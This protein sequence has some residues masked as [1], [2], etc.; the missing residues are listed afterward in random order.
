LTVEYG[1][2][3][4]GKTGPTSNKN[5]LSVHVRLTNRHRQ[6]KFSL[7]FYL[8]GESGEVL[9]QAEQVELL[10]T[11]HRSAPISGL[12]DLY[13][14]IG[15]GTQE[16]RSGFIWFLAEKPMPLKAIVMHD[17]ISDQRWSYQLNP[18]T[19]AGPKQAGY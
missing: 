12:S 18:K 9:P 16:E 6:R 5:C 13:P 14:P 10:M 19:V 15:L 11:G 8:A 17:R 1:V 3:S 4:F 7:K 2:L